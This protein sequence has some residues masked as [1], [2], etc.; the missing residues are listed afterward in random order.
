MKLCFPYIA[1]HAV[2]REASV[3]PYKPCIFILYSVPDEDDP[4]Q[5][6]TKEY[7]FSTEETE[8][9]VFSKSFPSLILVVHYF[10]VDRIFEAITEC[11]RLYPDSELS[12]DSDEESNTLEG[13]YFT[14]ID[15]LQHLSLEG[16]SVLNHLEHVIQQSEGHHRSIE[17]G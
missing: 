4:E 8:Q 14:T 15:G 5:E 3:F 2:S 11:Q 16:Q 10:I 17:N 6:V 1:V 12:S 9:R 7:R 13:G